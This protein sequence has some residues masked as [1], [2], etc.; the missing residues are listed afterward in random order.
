MKLVAH[1]D[2]TIAIVR[3]VDAAVAKEGAGWRFRFVVEGAR[4]L[5]GTITF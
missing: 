1:P 2:T 5:V 3:T 4:D